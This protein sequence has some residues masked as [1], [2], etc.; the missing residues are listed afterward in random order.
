MGEARINFDQLPPSSAMPDRINTLITRRNRRAAG[1]TGRRVTHS[2]PN[3]TEQ[4]RYARRDLN[5]YGHPQLLTTPHLLGTEAERKIYGPIFFLGALIVAAATERNVTLIEIP[6][7]E[8]LA[9][10]ARA[11]VVLSAYDKH[12]EFIGAEE[13]KE[14]DKESPPLPISPP[15]T[16]LEVEAVRR[17]DE[18][19]EARYPDA[20]LISRGVLAAA[21]WYFD[22]QPTEAA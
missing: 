20:Q 12:L 1:T 6:L 5:E 10:E 11:R 22:A 2:D 16:E 19:L 8:E 14:T 13:R 15:L 21:R 18:G 3:T 9:H 17:L 7:E 4:D